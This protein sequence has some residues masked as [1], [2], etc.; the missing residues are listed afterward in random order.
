MDPILEIAGRRGLRVIEDAC[1]AHGAEYRGR[2]IGS[3]GDLACYSFYYSK[4]LGAFGEGGAV[5]TDD[6][7]LAERVGLLRNHGSP[8]KYRHT[9]FG[10]NARPDELQSAILLLKLRDLDAGNR[11]RRE[12]AQRYSA[13]LAGLELR[14]P[15]TAAW[16]RPVF[17]LYAVHTR[18]RDELLEW[19]RVRG[20]GAA[21]HYPVPIH[22]QPGY[23]HVG[24]GPGELANAER[25]AAETLSLPMYPELADEEVDYVIDAVRAFFGG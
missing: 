21:I 23:G 3:L 4:N 14:T 15:T 19:L 16:A 9:T 1:Q 11:R 22:L 5:V 18:R 25:W 13:E 20:I 7:E 17:H 12:I 8:G 2:R 24:R 10:W 6:D